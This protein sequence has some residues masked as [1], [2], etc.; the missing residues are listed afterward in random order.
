MWNRRVATNIHLDHPNNPANRYAGII[1]E[2]EIYTIK[3]ASE[4]EILHQEGVVQ[5][6]YIPQ[7][8]VLGAAVGTK[9]GVVS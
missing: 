3:V 7:K 4:K 8:T 6:Q 1:G 5:L 9:L 2:G